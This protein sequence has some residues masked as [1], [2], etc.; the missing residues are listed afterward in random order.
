V[1][2]WWW[3]WG[4]SGEDRVLKRRDSTIPL[5][6]L[7]LVRSGLH[8]GAAVGDEAGAVVARAKGSYIAYRRRMSS[9]PPTH[10][11]RQVRAVSLITRSGGGT[12][13]RCVGVIPEGRVVKRR[14]STM[15]LLDLLVHSGLYPGRCRRWWRSPVGEAGAVVARAKGAYRR[16]MSSPPPAHGQRQVRAVSLITRSGRMPAFMCMAW[17]ARPSGP[18]HW[19]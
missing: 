5:L 15:P 6:D 18:E 2:W 9:P 13:A 10:G 1:G 3:W 19:R 11:Q 14:G 17:H 8:P 7:L 12:R 4:Y 16:R